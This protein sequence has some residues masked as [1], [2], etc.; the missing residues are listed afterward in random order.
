LIAQ[1]AKRFLRLIGPYPYNPYLIFLFFFAIFFSRFIPLVSFLPAGPERWR[2][3]GIVIVASAIPGLIFCAGSILLN[4]FRL[5]SSKSTILYIL[6]VAFFQY[7]NLLYL[8]FI[9]RRLKVQLGHSN[10]TL[11]SLSP[12]I[13]IA[14]LI[15]VLIALALMHQAERKISDRLDLATNL[16]KKLESER[17]GLIFSDERL[18]RHTSQFLHD[19]VQSDLMVVGMK[20][21]SIS[22]QSTPEINL[23]IEKA[24]SRLEET[25]AS[26]LRNI[27]QILTPN[28]EAANLRSAL[29]LLFEQYRASMDIVLQI[30]AA[31][32]E[33][34]SETLLGVFRIIEQSTLNALVHGPAKR[35]QVLI[36]KEI[37]GE[38][39][40]VIADDGPGANIESTAPGVGTAIIDSWIGILDG[41]K[42]IDS[43]P[44]HGYQLEVLFPAP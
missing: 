19:R 28:L 4:N 16:V 34:D 13:F 2:A 26:D 22:G 25:R 36:S 14:S 33:L 11:I 30:D 20:L 17:E 39:K 10:E 9:N 27:I 5:W 23:V 6:E 29:N 42:S 3:G 31:V 12:N 1:K 37:T 35:V 41:R 24:I 7:L 21:K 40:I 32:E 15:L 8:P 18:R 38:I 43:A 44:G